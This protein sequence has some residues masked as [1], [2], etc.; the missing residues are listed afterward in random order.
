V[1][2]LI[3][4][5]ALDLA[6]ETFAARVVAKHSGLR[7]QLRLVLRSLL[8]RV[9]LTTEEL[10]DLLTLMDPVEWAGVSE[11]DPGVGGEEFALALQVVELSGL[12][13]T[14]QDDLRASI[15]RRAMIRDDWLV[16]NETG[17]KDDQRVEEEMQQS[18]LFRAL[19]YVFLLEQ[20]D[21][22]PVRL[23]SPNDILQR[24]PFPAS[25]RG[26]LGENELDGVRKD[27]EK[28]QAKLE[29]FVEK[30]RLE[31]HYSGLVSS[32]QRALRDSIDEQGEQM[33]HQVTMGQ[34]NGD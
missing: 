25:L 6:Q 8:R 14:K 31:D 19:H 33:A 9:P 15:W 32:A 3:K 17:G 23:F 1:Q 11:E 21:G 22:I 18:S 20:V 29:T 27:I 13:S 34:T 2:R 4:K 30:G 7:R 10:V 24:Q 5:A 12:P 26:K 28:E 16:L